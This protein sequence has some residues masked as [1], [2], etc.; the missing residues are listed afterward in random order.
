ME[1]QLPN[2][3]EAEDR[4]D[5]LVN[6]VAGLQG[7]HHP[8]MQ[9]WVSIKFSLQRGARALCMVERLLDRGVENWHKGGSGQPILHVYLGL[10]ANEYKAYVEG[11]IKL[12]LASIQYTQV[13]HIRKAPTGWK[14][15]EGYVYIGRKHKRAPWSDGYFGNPFP[16][17]RGEPRGTT[18]ERYR[19]YFCE[20]MKDQEFAKRIQALRGKVLV[21]FC[22]PAACHGDV[23]AEYLNERKP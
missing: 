21:C 19:E 14:F 18:L 7:S 15:D 13:I 8:M 11:G 6:M 12:L 22:K 23:I 9:D 3:R 17:K 16:L 4:L 10:T 5:K 2:V 20:R 1:F